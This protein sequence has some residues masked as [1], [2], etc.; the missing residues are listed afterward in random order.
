MENR[1]A[2]ES[3]FEE[4]DFE[5]NPQ[6][7]QL[8]ITPLLF[9]R[10]DENPASARDRI[11]KAGADT[12]IEEKSVVRGKVRLALRPYGRYYSLRSSSKSAYGH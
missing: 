5:S 8:V 3:R 9:Q 1:H 2:S 11:A 7:E 10:S 6:I 12:R 4:I